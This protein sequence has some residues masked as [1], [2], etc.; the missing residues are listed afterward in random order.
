MPVSKS[1]TGERNGNAVIGLDQSGLSVELGMEPSSSL[2][3]LSCGN[4]CGVYFVSLFC[5]ALNKSFF[6]KKHNVRARMCGCWAAD[7]NLGC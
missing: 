1:I 4:L 2:R 5:F 3:T 7:I 6:R